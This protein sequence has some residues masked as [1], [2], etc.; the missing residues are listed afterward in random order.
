[1]AR[2]LTFPNRLEGLTNLRAKMRARMAVP[3]PEIRKRV[4]DG[5]ELALRMMWRRWCAGLP[6]ESFEA[7]LPPAAPAADA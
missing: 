1:M 7:V 6:A 2:G 3:P 5:V 4:A